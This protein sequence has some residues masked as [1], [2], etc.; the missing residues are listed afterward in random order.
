[1]RYWIESW[2]DVRAVTSEIAD[3][4]GEAHGIVARL[5]EGELPAPEREVELQRL[6]EALKRLLPTPRLERGLGYI[7]LDVAEDTLAL[8]ER[9]QWTLTDILRANKLWEEPPSEDS[10]DDVAYLVRATA[11]MRERIERRY[12][13]EEAERQAA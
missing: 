3:V 5:V 7:L 12:R 8:L 9:A 6:H 13:R 4:V 10:I 2:D 1:M 11:R